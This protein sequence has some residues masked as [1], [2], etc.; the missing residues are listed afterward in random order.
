MD[1]DRHLPVKVDQTV[2][3]KEKDS[4]APTKNKTTAARKRPIKKK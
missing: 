4:K 3:D 2:L 1:H